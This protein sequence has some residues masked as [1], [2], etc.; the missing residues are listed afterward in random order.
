MALSPELVGF[1]R[2]GLDRGLPREQT[3][4]GRI[5]RYRV[6]D[7]GPAAGRLDPA[8]RGVPVC[9]DVHGAVR[10]RHHHGGGAVWADRSRS[11]RPGRHVPGDDPRVIRMSV[12][13]LVVASPVFTFVTG[14]IRRGVEAQLRSR[15]SR[16]R[17]Q[18]TYLTLFVASCF[19]GGCRHGP[20]LQLSQRRA[21]SALRAE[22]SH[23]DC[24]CRR[25]IRLLPPGSSRGGAGPPG[26]AGAAP[27]RPAVGPR[28]CGGGGGVGRGSGGDRLADRPASRA[29]G[30]TARAGHRGHLASHRPL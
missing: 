17:L 6:P 18:L 2:E 7:P 1:V 11:A 22:G 14:V 16:P 23:R 30:R 4:T 10:Q 3:G 13:A 27:S 15:T 24:D 26:S 5:C 9:R 19:S 28:R 8:A 29:A 12:S 21:D 25:G 20:R